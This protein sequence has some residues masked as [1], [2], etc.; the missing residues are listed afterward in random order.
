[1]TPG[2]KADFALKSKCRSQ[3]RTGVHLNDDIMTIADSTEN[4]FASAWLPFTLYIVYIG[5]RLSESIMLLKNL[6]G[7]PILP[8]YL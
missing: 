1:L 5:S 7:N 8:A 3:I 4:C 6:S 2:E